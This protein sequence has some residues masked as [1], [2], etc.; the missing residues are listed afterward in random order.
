MQM[1]IRNSYP[2]RILSLLRGYIDWGKRQFAAP[3]PHFIKQACLVRNSFPNATWVETG[4]YLGQTT[5]VLSKYALKVYSIEPEP[6][7]F[8]KAKKYF[9]SYNNVEIINGTSEEV[10]PSL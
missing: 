7:L 1:M 2:Y 6:T 9:S 5:H 4:T 10:F 8:A 3:S